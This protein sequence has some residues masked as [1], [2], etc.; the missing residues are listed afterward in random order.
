VSIIAGQWGDR[1][2]RGL[3]TELFYP[4]KDSPPGGP[5]NKWELRA[6]E[7]CERCPAREACL[8]AAL[9]FPGAEQHGVAGGMTAGQR[10]QVLRL[11][12]R[13]PT[14]SYLAALSGDSSLP[15][16]VDALAVARLVAGEPVPGATPD[17]VAHA[18]IELHRTGHTSTSIAG[19]LGVQDRQVWR[20]IER[21]RAGAPLVQQSARGGRAA[22]AGAVA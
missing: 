3:D 20:W 17:E 4:P 15:R 14:R 6:L 22:R 18:A 21:D 2:C 13:Q 11:Q 5:M 1:A 12:R 9:Q 10:R 16:E 19:Q 7:V 8:E